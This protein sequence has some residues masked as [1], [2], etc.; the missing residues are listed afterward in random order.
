M[1]KVLVAGGNSFLAK[2]LLCLLDGES[3]KVAALTRNMDD[4][5]DKG[6]ISYVNLDLNEYQNI[7]KHIKD[8][9]VYIPFAWQGTKREER[10]SE[11]VNEFSYRKLLQSVKTAIEQCGCKKII[12]PGT[13]HEYRNNGTPIDENTPCIPVTPYGKYK[14]KLYNEA[15][16]YCSKHNVTFIELRMFSIYGEN[17]K[18]TKMINTWLKKLL[19]NEPIN[20]TL[21]YQLY[22]FLHVD[23]VVRAF[24]TAVDK[25][26]LSGAYNLAAAEHRRL[27]DFVDEMKE[28]AN[29]ESDIH[30]GA[31]PHAN[32]SIPH[33]IFVSNK[34][35][36]ELEWYPKVEFSSGVL[37]MIEYC[38]RNGCL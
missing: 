27:R 35:K 36:D 16:E 38:Q 26:N 32:S 20:M 34:T 18:P 23:D 22:S 21:G 11:A 5:K 24:K 4:T 7:G 9:D 15:G 19:A 17:D 25:D 13:C 29:S 31:V 8:C 28:L 14:N 37:R 10:E 6:N 1:K 12:L 3:Y 30:Y 33:T 2:R